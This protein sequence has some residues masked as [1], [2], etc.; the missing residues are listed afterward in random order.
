MKF[1]SGTSETL[2]GLVREESAL[3][4]ASLPGYK[5]HTLEKNIWKEIAK[6][7]NMKNVN[8]KYTL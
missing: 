4:D 6:E 3:Y 1:S 7:M 2:I 5:D 8:C